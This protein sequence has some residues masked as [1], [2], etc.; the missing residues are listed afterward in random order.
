MPD[1]PLDP[2]RARLAMLGRPHTPGDVAAALRGLGV[3][4]TD[5]AIAQAM[6]ELRLASVGAGRLEPLLQAQ[7][8]SD[9]LV[10]GPDAV[11]VDRGGGL[12]RADLRFADDEPATAGGRH[13][14]Q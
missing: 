13:Q 6:R 14:H 12:E 5:A 10:N 4:V 8:V 3:V 2:L 1:L 7:G 11:F 9:V